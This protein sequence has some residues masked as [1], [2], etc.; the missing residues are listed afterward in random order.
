[1]NKSEMP[2]PAGYYVVNNLTED[3]GDIIRKDDEYYKT[4]GNRGGFHPY[5][6][7]KNIY[8]NFIYRDIIILRKKT[9]R[10]VG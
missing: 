9:K 1:M 10:K 4:N 7:G 8:H 2:I 6:H 3:N 5:W